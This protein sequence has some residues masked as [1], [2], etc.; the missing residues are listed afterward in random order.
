MS[1]GEM[2]D[3]NIDELEAGPELDALVAERVMGWQ[4]FGLH[5]QLWDKQPPHRQVMC[6]AFELPKFSGEIAA[7][8]EVVENLAPKFIDFELVNRQNRLALTRF[9]WGHGPKEFFQGNASTAP[10]AICR[11]ALK[12]VN[13]T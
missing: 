5:N 1:E 12:A 7:A 8:W 10:L 9:V 11:A 13:A 6:T 3:M 4:R 2:L